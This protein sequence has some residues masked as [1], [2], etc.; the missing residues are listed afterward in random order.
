MLEIQDYAE[1]GPV[2]G[3]CQNKVKQKRTFK[4]GGRDTEI[5]FITSLQYLGL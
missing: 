5:N 4:V 2:D 3:K 1:R